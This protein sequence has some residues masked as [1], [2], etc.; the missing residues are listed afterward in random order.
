MESM[1]SPYRVLDLTQGGCLLCGQTLG[2]MGADVIQVEAPGGSPSRNIGPFYKDIP[3]PQ[4]SLFWFAYNANKRSIT[5]NIETA[6]GQELFRRLVK[7]AD[8][9]IESSPPGYMDGLGLGYS[10]LSQINPRIIMVS[11]TPFGQTGP[12]SHYKG[13][14]LIA[15]ANGGIL[16]LC[17]DPDRPPVWISFPQASLHAASEAVVG[18][19][20]AHWH[21]EMTGE[22]QQVDVSTQDCIVPLLLHAPLSWEMTGQRSAR[23]GA[24]A[25]NPGGSKT[26][27]ACPCKDGT[28]GIMFIGGVSPIGVAAMRGLVKWMDEDG[29]ASDWLK[30]RTFVDM[31]VSQEDNDRVGAEFANFL[32]TKTKS[33]I[34][35]ESLSRRLLV[36]PFNTTEDIAK[37]A[38]LKAREYWIDVDHSELDDRITYCGPSIKSSESPFRITRR[39]PL[40]GEHNG[41]VYEQELG[42]SA[43]QMVFLKQADVI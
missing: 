32:A 6:D 23:T 21:R 31:V 38:Q 19:L 15:W 12:K 13:N 2:D 16:Y 25:T 9:V 4:K 39:A 20:I 10:A 11:I 3:D 33:E 22:G 36:V 28:V 26:L 14:D 40:I 37:S 8:F 43:E 29:M 41:E 18:A 42:L 1:L 34:W 27:A 35:K 24:Y 5:L 17:G 7:T 30:S